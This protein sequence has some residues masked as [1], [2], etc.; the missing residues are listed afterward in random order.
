MKGAHVV[1]GD[2]QCRQC[3]GR[4]LGTRLR[5]FRGRHLQRAQL[6]TVELARAGAQGRIAIAPYP[7]DDRARLLQHGFAR[8]AR[9]AL[10]H[11]TARCI[12]QELPVDD[13]HQGLLQPGTSMRPRPV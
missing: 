5:E 2:A 8:N 13:L 6:D 10:Q 3:I 11:G 4:H 9:G 12:V 1:T 7:V